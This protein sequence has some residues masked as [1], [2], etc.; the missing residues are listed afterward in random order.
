MVLSFSHVSNYGCKGSS[1]HGETSVQH[2]H[3]YHFI[4]LLNN[5]WWNHLLKLYFDPRVK[6]FL[7]HNKIKS[8]GLILGNNGPQTYV[9]QILWN[10]I[11]L[12]ILLCG[13]Y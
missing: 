10:A 11:L 9:S 8:K 5:L 12:S 7:F 13:T 1:S 3:K 2:W 4:F 6:G